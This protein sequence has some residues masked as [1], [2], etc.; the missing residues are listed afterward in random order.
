MQKK[1]E[2]YPMSLMI[3][4]IISMLCLVYLYIIM[5]ANFKKKIYNNV[6][7]NMYGDVLMKV[8]Y[9]IPEMFTFF[10]PV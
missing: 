9:C 7:V 8:T 1:L 3:I 2:W 4:I 10:T 6:V 5:L